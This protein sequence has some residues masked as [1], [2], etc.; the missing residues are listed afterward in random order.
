M[1]TD[2]SI[3]P[4]AVWV[5]DHQVD[6]STASRRVLADLLIRT[7]L[8]GFLPGRVQGWVCGCLLCIS[9]LLAESSD[10]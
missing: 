7:G 5:P 4:G 3:S 2:T 8:W 6:P 9:H 10:G 1:D